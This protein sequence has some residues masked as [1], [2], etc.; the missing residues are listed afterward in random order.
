MAAVAQRAMAK[1][2]DARYASAGELAAAA[3]AAARGTGAGAPAAPTELSR[4]PA[5]LTPTVGRRDE[6]A[7]VASL[8]CRDDVRLVTLLG[9]GGVGKSRLSLELARA[10]EHDFADGAWFVE[11]ATTTGA[12]DVAGAIA[13]S[14]SLRPGAGETPEQALGRFLGPRQ[15]L[16]VLDNFEHVLPAARLVSELLSG[17]G[18]L[19]V[20]ATSRAPLGIQPE[21]RVGVEPL[22]LPRGGTPGDVKRS[23]ACAL[24]LARAES[25][26]ASISLDVSADAVA[27]ICRRLDGLPL[28]IELAAARVPLLEPPEL[29]ARLDHALE[30][31]GTGTRDAPA[32][33]R[34]LRA[35]IDW[36]YRLLEPAEA[37]AFARFA[38]FAGGASIHSAQHVTGAGLDALEGL[39]DKQLLL[40]RSGPGGITRLAMLETVREYARERLDA[41]PGAHEV[42]SRHCRHYVALAERAEPELYTHGEREWL[43]RLDADADNL[44]A[45]FDWSVRRGDPRQALRLAGVLHPFLAIRGRVAEGIDLVERALAAAGDAAPV[46]ERARGQRAYVHLLVASGAPY[47]W[48]GSRHEAE[49]QARAALDLSREAGEPAGIADALL[50]LSSFEAIDTAPPR[51][52]ERALAEEALVHA[53]EAGDDRLAGFALM[54]RALAG[55]VDQ[56]EPELEQ[57]VAAL[58][59]TGDSRHLVWLYSNAA[60]NA[61]GVGMAE[62]ARPLLARAL[63]LARELGYPL[64]LALACGNAGLAALFTGDIDAAQEAFGE[65]LRLCWDQAGWLAGEGLVG[66]A[67]IAARRGDSEL[68]ARLIGAAGAIA[69]LAEDDVTVRLRREFLAPARTVLGDERWHAAERD[70]AG[71]SFDEAILTAL[72]SEPTVPPPVTD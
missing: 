55:P 42:E 13:T 49:T 20:M 4:L 6:C 37:Q 58:Q 38:V 56:S 53:R 57:A 69:P 46:E 22:G 65:Q 45:A 9:P 27:A 68:A 12:D 33:Q 40:R 16:L 7:S 26:G 72:E 64:D 54:T 29:S 19:T 61:L 2:P 11:L 47:D 63:P 14:L 24:F 3:L 17:C 60:Y 66:F 15:A 10:L 36:S 51:P 5:P 50:A 62:H 39:V 52:R 43:P 18:G 44:R 67:A 59:Q 21:H 28:A 32:R 71:L 48:K 70:G 34:T 30:A 1:E 25:Q 41:D 31:L 23:A 35:T 8:L